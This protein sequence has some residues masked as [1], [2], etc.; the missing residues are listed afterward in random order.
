M[1][2]EHLLKEPG[3][4]VLKFW[5][6]D[7]G[8]VLQ[9][10][11]VDSGGVKPSYLGPP[12]SY[13]AGGPAKAEAGHA[14]S[15]IDGSGAFDTG[16]YR[17]LFVE[18]GHSPQEVAAKSTVHSQLFHGDPNTLPYISPKTPTGRWLISATSIT[19]TYDPRAVLRR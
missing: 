15:D 7:P 19:T 3:E 11:V 2:S 17:N 18:A 8:I 6:V 5:M 14:L 9:K 1:T 16:K 12:E 10:I 4:H 13:F